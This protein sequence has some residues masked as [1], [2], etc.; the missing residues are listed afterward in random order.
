MKILVTGSSGLVG[1]SLQDV[2]N[3]FERKNDYIFATSKHA[4]LRYEDQVTRLFSIY[5][6]DIV[7]HLASIVGGLYANLNDNKNFLI[8]NLKMHIN[9]VE[10]CSKYKVKKLINVLST[11]VFPDKNVKFPLT[12]DQI[13]D[14]FSHDSNYGYAY[15]KRML[16]IMSRT[17]IS[18]GITVINLIPTNLY[19]HHDNYNLER[20]HVIPALIHKCWLAKQNKTPFVIRGNGQAMRQ[21]VYADDLAAI[22]DTCIYDMHTNCTFIVSPSDIYEYSISQIVDII[23]KIMHFT[24]QIIYDRAYENGQFRKTCSRKELDKV[25]P[26][27]EFTSLEN[28][29]SKTID[30]FI[31]NFNNIRK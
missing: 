13:H 14:G 29:L 12:S 24:G 19:G 6:P 3:M 26:N 31:N 8:E 21:F 11:C 16:H 5:K 20:A 9:I 17:L 28:G 2:I 10:A 18:E 7:V 22:I 4:D 25:I 15:S 23:T 30:Y 27:F 1:R